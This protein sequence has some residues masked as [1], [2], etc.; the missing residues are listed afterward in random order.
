MPNLE[1]LHN[2]L[3]EAVNS[4]RQVNIFYKEVSQREGIRMRFHPILYGEDIYHY[5]F[6][7]GYLPFYKKYYKYFLDNIEKV[8]VSN[9]AFD[10]RNDA[11]YFNADE[12]LHIATYPGFQEDGFIYNGNIAREQ[13]LTK[14]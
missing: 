12:E 2:K 9:E 14:G 7:W 8:E 10:L 1:K 5:A 3:E 4:K 6:V 13:I 11:V